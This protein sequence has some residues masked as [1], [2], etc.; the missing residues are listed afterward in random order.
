[1]NEFVFPMDDLDASRHDDRLQAEHAGKVAQTREATGSR[2]RCPTCGRSGPELAWY[3]FSSPP[4]TWRH[5]CGRA[6]IMA[7]C[8]VDQ[9]QVAFFGTVMN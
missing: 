6:G 5:L 8:D 2:T 3:F 9:A 1:M 4:T 7:F